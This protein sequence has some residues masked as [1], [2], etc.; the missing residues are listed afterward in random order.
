[1]PC[2]KPSMD[3]LRIPARMIP[4]RQGLAGCCARA[5]EVANAD[6]LAA[7]QPKSVRDSRGCIGASWSSRCPPRGGLDALCHRRRACASVRRNFKSAALAPDRE[8]DPDQKIVGAVIE[9]DADPPVHREIRGDE[10]DKATHGKVPR[11]GRTDP[12]GGIEC[13][14]LDEAFQVLGQVE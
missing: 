2:T 8:A 14:P 3:G 4:T 6:A 10:I 7:A 13:V 5:V 9:A 12:A 1:M 11:R